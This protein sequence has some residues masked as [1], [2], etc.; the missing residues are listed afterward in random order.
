MS[1]ETT[2]D[3]VSPELKTILDLDKFVTEKAT[4]LNDQRFTLYKQQELVLNT[5]TDL[6]N[7]LV[8][9]TRAKEQTLFGH[10][11]KLQAELKKYQELAGGLSNSVPNSSTKVVP[12]KALATVEEEPQSRADNVVV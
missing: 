3:N 4:I 5:Q 1:S 6:I 8:A 12:R 7:G 11:E 10:I 2:T 9:L